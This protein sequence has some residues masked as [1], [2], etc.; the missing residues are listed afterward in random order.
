[1][2]VHPGHDPS[3]FY[4]VFMFLELHAGHGKVIIIHT[5]SKSKSRWYRCRLRTCGSYWG[6]Y[7]YCQH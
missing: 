4:C 5:H 3:G 2:A 1:M 6:C 7:L